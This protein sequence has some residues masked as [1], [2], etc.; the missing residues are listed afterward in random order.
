MSDADHASLLEVLAIL[1]GRFLL[2]G[3]PSD[4]YD[5]YAEHYGWR[6]VDFSIDNKS[7]SKK[8]K[9]T[10]TECVWMNY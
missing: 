9:D 8:E 4:L 5:E 2:S 10:K 7:S 3:Y 1:K 6:R